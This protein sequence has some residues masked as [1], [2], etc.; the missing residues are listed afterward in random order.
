MAGGGSL[1]PRLQNL[2]ALFRGGTL[3][4][5]GSNAPLG[6]GTRPLPIQTDPLQMQTPPGQGLPPT[7]PPGFFGT[8]P[9]P[10]RRGMPGVPLRPG[11]TSPSRLPGVMGLQNRFPIGQLSRARTRA[12]M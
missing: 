2:A 10:M 5:L 6:L 7:V 4:V 3:G 1:D 9:M 8:R 12:Y 11:G